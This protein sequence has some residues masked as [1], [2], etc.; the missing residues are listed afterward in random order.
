MQKAIDHAFY[1]R[2]ILAEVIKVEQLTIQIISFVV[3]RDLFDA[4]YST[5]MVEDKKLR[6]DIAQIQE[7]VRKENIELKWVPGPEMLADCLT[8]KTGNSAELL[9]VL[10]TG[11]LKLKM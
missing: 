5:K 6:C 7:S 9:Q 11:I 4:I 1:L 10:K 8:K 2:A 3:S